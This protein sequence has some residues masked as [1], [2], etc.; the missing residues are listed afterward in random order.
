MR[1]VYQLSKFL[2]LAAF[3]FHL[4]HIEKASANA[5]LCVD[6]FS[7][8]KSAHFSES[9]KESDQIK[10]LFQNRIFDNP[11]FYL[12]LSNNPQLVRKLLVN[13]YGSHFTKE[14]LPQFKFAEYDYSALLLDPGIADRAGEFINFSKNYTE[15]HPT[16]SLFNLRKAFSTYL[17]KVTLYR[18]MILTPEQAID[19]AKNGIDSAGLF[20]KTESPEKWLTTGHGPVRDIISRVTEDNETASLAI[21]ASEIPEVAMSAVSYRIDGATGK[22]VYLFK[23]ETDE[24]NIVRE[25]QRLGTI[26]YFAKLAKT[27]QNTQLIF[28]SP[29]DDYFN[30]SWMSGATEVFFLNHIPAQDITSVTQVKDQRPWEIINFGSARGTLNLDSDNVNPRQFQVIENPKTLLQY[31]QGW[32]HLRH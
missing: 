10:E 4:F 6:L 15:N 11:D 30:S 13:W 14:W 2:I 1:Q 31:N 7:T 23:I 9:T 27:I 22:F 28:K 12:R 20:S 24:I 5:L 17:G 19:A 3:F 16:V 18:T 26:P 21:S 8:E 29:N 32:E 25:N